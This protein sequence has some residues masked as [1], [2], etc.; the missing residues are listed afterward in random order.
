MSEYC[1]RPPSRAESFL[2]G[3]QASFSIDVRNKLYSGS[4]CQTSL[5]AES[6][7]GACEV[8]GFLPHARLAAV[9]T[10]QKFSTLVDVALLR[11]CIRM[12][13]RCY[14]LS[15]GRLR[16]CC[17]PCGNAR[18]V[19]GGRY[20]PKFYTRWAS[21]EQMGQLQLDTSERKPDLGNNG[22]C[23]GLM[24][25]LLPL[26]SSQE[27]DIHCSLFVRYGLPKDGPMFPTAFRRKSTE[28]AIQ[29]RWSLASVDMQRPLVYISP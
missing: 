12:A 28:T 8:I 9:C 16:C 18:C 20:S 14:M 7:P 17:T 26:P 27:S 11:A 1:L 6:R 19:A 25:P 4:H 13:G 15:L 29:T 5:R 10:L 3:I 23:G 22:R 2:S 21:G 24:V